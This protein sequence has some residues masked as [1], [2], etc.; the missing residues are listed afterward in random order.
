MRLIA[1]LLLTAALA[2]PAGDPAG[3][4]FWKSSELKGYA[5]TLA[6]KVNAQHVASQAL[7]NPGN[8]H[9]QIAHR[10]GSGEG[11]WHEKQ[12]D[13]FVVQSGEATLVYGGEMVNGRQTGAGEMRAAS[14]R[15]GMEKALAAGDVVTI[16]AKMPHQMKL[17]AGKEIT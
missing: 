5:K 17:A 14:I 11:E 4:F 3:F 7:S 15:G 16:P 1:L 2:L 8:Y 12:A 6:P 9:F 13:I 10:E